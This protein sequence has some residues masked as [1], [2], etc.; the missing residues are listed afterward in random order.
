MQT[1]DP[2]FGTPFQG[3]HLRWRQFQTHQLHQELALFDLDRVDAFLAKSQWR[4]SVNK[5]GVVQL[6]GESRRYSL[7]RTFAYQQVRIH[8]DPEDR[9]LVFY[10]NDNPDQELRRHPI[11]GVTAYDLIGMDNPEVD[12]VPQQL[13][14]L[15]DVLKG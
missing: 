10:L 9:H 15:P 2:A 6:G 12:L 8:F 14:L 4:R 1:H 5:N 3:C 13:A 7:G 11:R